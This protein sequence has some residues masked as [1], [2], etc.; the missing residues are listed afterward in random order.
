MNRPYTNERDRMAAPS[1]PQLPNDTDLEVK[2]KKGEY[3]E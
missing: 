1:P 3:W 2:V